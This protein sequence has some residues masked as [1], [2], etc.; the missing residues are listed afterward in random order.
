MITCIRLT[1]NQLKNEEVEGDGVM[2]DEELNL[3]EIETS[4]TL[5]GA[6]RY[7]RCRS[8]GSINYTARTIVDLRCRSNGSINYTARTIVRLYVSLGNRSEW[9]ATNLF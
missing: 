7:M 9:R 3:E 5:G 1:L 8:N 4:H 6:G 2:K